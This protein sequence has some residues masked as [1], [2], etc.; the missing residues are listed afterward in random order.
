M[1]ALTH[2]HEAEPRVRA[3]AARQPGTWASA[4]TETSVKGVD[5]RQIILQRVA[6]ERFKRKADRGRDIGDRFGG[7]LTFPDDCPF[8][9]KRI[10]DVAT[11]V[12]LDDDLELVHGTISPLVWAVY[13]DIVDTYHHAL[14]CRSNRANFP[15]ARV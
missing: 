5:H 7:G 3:L 9:S 15:A 4:A 8:E 11:R 10:G 6:A 13:D 2:D 1:L 12:L 14:Q